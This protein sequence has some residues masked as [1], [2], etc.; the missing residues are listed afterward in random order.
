MSSYTAPPP[1][2]EATWATDCLSLWGLRRVPMSHPSA[3]HNVHAG[4]EKFH[5][6]PTEFPEAFGKHSLV[7]TTQTPS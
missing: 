6:G 7:V 1:S 5:L 4:E 2:A 3:K